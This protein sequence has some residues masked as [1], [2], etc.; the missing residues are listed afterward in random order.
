MDKSIYKIDQSEKIYSVPESASF[1][2]TS[3]LS[4]PIDDDCIQVLPVMKILALQ[5]HLRQPR[6]IDNFNLSFL[7]TA[8][9]RLSG[10]PWSHQIYYIVNLGHKKYLEGNVKLGTGNFRTYRNHSSFR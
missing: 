2:S 10:F 9:L 7:M 4:S 5:L 1:T 6:S 8:R 3:I